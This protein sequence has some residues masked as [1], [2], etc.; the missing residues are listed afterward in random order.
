MNSIPP[1]YSSLGTY[2]DH[3]G[4]DIIEV[5][6]FYHCDE[7]REDYHNHCVHTA[8]KVNKLLAKLNLPQVREESDEESSH[9]SSWES[10]YFDFS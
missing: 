6:G 9:N 1:N 5:Q 2:C 7:C 3:C 8:L 10:D 4:Q